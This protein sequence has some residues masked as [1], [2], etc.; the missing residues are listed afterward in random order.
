MRKI[1]HVP[2]Q[3]IKRYAMRTLLSLLL[4]LIISPILANP[5]EGYC[6]T[7]A[8]QRPERIHILGDESPKI[9]NFISGGKPYRFEETGGNI[10]Q[11]IT[12]F[13]EHNNALEKVKLSPNSPRQSRDNCDVI[14]MALSKNGWL[15][16]DGTCYDEVAHVDLSVSPPVISTAMDVTT[17]THTECLPL[18]WNCEVMSG[19]YSRA[20]ERVFVSSIARSFFGLFPPASFEIVEGKSKPLP[21]E[22]SNVQRETEISGNQRLFFDDLPMLNGVLFKGANGEALFYDGVKVT[23]L[24]DSHIYGEHFG[25]SVHIAPIS[26]RVFLSIYSHSYGTSF[27]VELNPN[28]TLRPILLPDKFAKDVLSP[29]E[30]FQKN[31]VFWVSINHNSLNIEIGGELRSI[32]KTTESLNL[33]NSA[34]IGTAPDDAIVFNVLNTITKNDKDYFIVRASPSVQCMAGLDPDKPVVL[35]NEK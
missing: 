31:D 21:V 10:G 16:I 3:T 9:V 17:L 7:Q 13:D 30:F 5:I 28:L 18:A 25:W 19:Y 27:L 33:W 11:S 20:L 26:K 32:I 23:S 34:Y 12:L 29:F 15:W 14:D 24:L 4:F 2:C 8:R 6:L 22:L 35:G 1:T